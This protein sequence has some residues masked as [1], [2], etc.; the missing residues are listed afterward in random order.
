MRSSIAST[1][2]IAIVLAASV[3]QAQSVD[4]PR[5]VNRM[6]GDFSTPSI[7]PGHDGILSFTVNNPDP[8]NLTGVM[9]DTAISISIYRYATLE[10]S[11]PV[12]EVDE[13]PVFQSSGTTMTSVVCGDIQP[14]G[15]VTLPLT[16]VTE[17]G[18]AHGSYFS[19]CSY[20]V[21]FN[22]T[23]SYQGEN[24]TMVSR[25]HFTDAQWEL[26]TSGETGAGEINQT[27]LHEL[28]YDGII[29]D[30]AF[31]VRKNIPIWPAFMLAGLTVLSGLA[32]FSFFVLDNPGRYPRLEI[33][34]L[35]LSGRLNLWKRRIFRMPR[36]P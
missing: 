5:F 31:S 3:C 30:T 26:L 16:I 13:P 29:P 28:G 23:F 4:E 21:R 33:K 15:N 18:T 25:G 27:Y 20:F 34:L 35:R 11:L 6:L 2:V 24:Y 22:L 12:E 1:L 32:A 19:Q 8:A 9:E 14:G 10:E 7:E 17:R 36:K